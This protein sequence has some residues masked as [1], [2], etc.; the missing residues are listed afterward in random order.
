MK[1]GV[2]F[3]CDEKFEKHFDIAARTLRAVDPDVPAT[4][5][6]IGLGGQPL[7]MKWD[8][9]Y[10]CLSREMLINGR[11]NSVKSMLFELTNYDTI[12][13]YDCDFVFKQPISH[14]LQPL[15]SFIGMCLGNSRWPQREQAKYYHVYKCL[16]KLYRDKIGETPMFPFAEPECQVYNAGFFI[17]NRQQHYELFEQW[18]LMM[19]LDS[20]VHRDNPNTVDQWTLNYLA[21]TRGLIAQLPMIYNW[22]CHLPATPAAVGIHYA[23]DPKLHLNQ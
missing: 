22:H 20:V 7:A 13:H 1:Q 23:A 6:H 18:Q 21:Q 12:V 17:A 9:D 10:L 11:I 4:L 14:L 16:E 8:M 15:G 19:R 5:I 3:Y 2:V